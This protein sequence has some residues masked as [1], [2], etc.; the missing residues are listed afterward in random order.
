MESRGWVE[1]W[2]FGFSRSITG[3]SKA[4]GNRLMTLIEKSENQIIIDFIFH[5][6]KLFLKHLSLTKTMGRQS[7]E[8][9]VKL[10][11]LSKQRIHP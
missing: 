5:Y 11:L 4:S 9:V 1:V 8:I 2:V 7:L 10:Y 3:I 6:L